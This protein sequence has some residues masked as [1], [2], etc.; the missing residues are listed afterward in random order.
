[1]DEFSVNISVNDCCSSKCHTSSNSTT[2]I[3]T[4]LSGF[5]SL[6]HCYYLKLIAV[7]PTYVVLSID[8][9]RIFFVRKAFI[10]IPLKLCIPNECASHIITINVNSITG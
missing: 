9:G 10:N 7:N 4:E 5:I 8:N 3:F 1:M 6:Q 2:E